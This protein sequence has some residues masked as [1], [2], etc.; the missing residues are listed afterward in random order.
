MSPS[1]PRK[2]EEILESQKEK[3]TATQA[4]KI[5][6]DLG[7]HQKPVTL[8]VPH[9]K[10][11]LPTMNSFQPIAKI[12][13]DLA[14]LDQLC[15]AKRDNTPLLNVRESYDS[16]ATIENTNGSTMNVLNV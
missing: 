12:I 10:N 2:G 3:Q 8:F 6:V 1:A 16:N 7:Q 5:A 11:S 15:K 4:N 9:T 13:E 14:T